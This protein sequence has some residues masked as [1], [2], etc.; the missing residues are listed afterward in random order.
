M[1]HTAFDWDR[2][3]F[4]LSMAAAGAT[5]ALRGV[6]AQ[7]PGAATRRGIRLGF[8]NFS[9][10]A[11]GWKAP[12][13]IDY[14]A[15]L[16]VDTLMLSDLGVY[17][18]LEDEAL[19]AVGELARRKGIEL[20]VG[21]GSI[22]PT[23]ASYKPKRWGPAVDHLRLLVRVAR[24]VGSR[25]ARCYLGTR[26]DRQGAGGIYRHIEEMV[27]VCKAVRA[28]ALDAGI[29]IAIE[30]HAGDMQAWELV[31]LIEAAGKD[32]VG[33]TMDA[34]NATW[35]LEDPMVNLEILGPHAV[36]SGMRD[37][38]VWE[39]DKG[40]GVM[41]ANMGQGVVDWQAYLARFEQLCPQCP[42]ILEICSY[43]WQHEARY[44]EPGWWAAF[45]RARA[46]EF[47]RFVALAKRGKE[48]TLPEGRPA[49]T[50]SRELEQRQQQW[51]LE[52]SLR[53]C[54]RVLGL[55]LR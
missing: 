17:E 54:K 28:E 13:L 40:A 42:F 55:G 39:T 12:R 51:D 48:Y 41:W 20:Q 29:R 49:G 7:E 18:S 10:R 22:C 3:R 19:Q 25:V 36:T 53:Y 38:A 37:S 31:E 24:A 32:F 4:L 15:S 34:G 27:N 2:R 1:D 46:D 14:A 43:S 23:S 52:Q 30:N 6:Q 45:P 5:E 33:A 11:L 26:R 44:L 16:K 9:I 21:T 47:A 50:K 35:T 8:D